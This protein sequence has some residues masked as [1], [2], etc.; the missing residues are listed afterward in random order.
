MKKTLS[1][2]SFLIAGWL[3]LVVFGGFT[4]RIW[5]TQPIVIT[6]AP[7]LIQGKASWYSKKSPGIRKH[8]ANNEIFDDTALTAAMWGVPF[9]QFVRVTNPQNGKSIVVRINDRGPHKRY[10]KKGRIIDLTKTAF[11]QIADPKKGL[12]RIEIELL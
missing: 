10:V 2:L 7:V 3:C 6:P 11:V 4:P 9:G 8:T 5:T 1:Q 12:V